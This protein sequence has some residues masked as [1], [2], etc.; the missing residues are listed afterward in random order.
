MNQ[1]DIDRIPIGSLWVDPHGMYV[2]PSTV[3]MVIGFMGSRAEHVETLEWDVDTVYHG[4]FCI[5]SMLDNLERI[6]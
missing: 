3:I 5:D 4:S 1:S 6:G 2:T